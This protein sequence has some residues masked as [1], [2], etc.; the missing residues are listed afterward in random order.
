MTGQQ[1]APA[2]SRDSRIAR[3]SVRV[4]AVHDASAPAIVARDLAAAYG[5]RIVLREVTFDLRAGAHLAVVGPNG[6]GK[7]TLLKVIGGLLPW[8]RGT[9][10]V[11][12]HAPRDHLCIAYV[13]QRSDVDWRFPVTVTDVVLMGLTGKLGPLRRASE[14]DRR[15]VASAIERVGLGDRAH[16]Q[17]GELSGGEQ[18]RMFIARAIAQEAEIVLM[19]EPL[20]GLDVP[21]EV[22]VLALLD[23]LDRTTLLVALHDLDVAAAH[24]DRVLLLS[25]RMIGFGAPD[26]VFLPN[27]LEAAYGGCVRMARTAGGALVVHDSAGS[28]EVR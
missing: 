10:R 3:R 21:S 22:D 11:H 15:L 9:I 24:F 12:G 28:R 2:A 18:Q 4:S 17:I 20:A 25:E 19:D 14:G 27:A 7:S 26:D 5:D 23:R 1:R 6:A 16:R 8:T 13:P